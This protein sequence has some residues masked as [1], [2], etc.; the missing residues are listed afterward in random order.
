M[1]SIVFINPIFKKFA[2][3]RRAA[4]SFFAHTPEELN[5]LCLAVDD[6]S[7]PEFWERQDWT[8]WMKDLPEDRVVM[9]RFPHNGGLTRSW[10]W[11]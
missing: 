9:K 5:P 8:A 2:Y 7:P 1:S 6:F 10:N 3:A 4:R 11:G